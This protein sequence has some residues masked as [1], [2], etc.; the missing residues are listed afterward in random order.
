[1]YYITILQNNYNQKCFFCF[2]K[3]CIERKQVLILVH[4]FLLG[5][6]REVYELENVGNNVTR[7]YSIILT[8][9]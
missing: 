4:H 2:R 8:A 5:F 9:L 6:G 7:V 1:M 3:S